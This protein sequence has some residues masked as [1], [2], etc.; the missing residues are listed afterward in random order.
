MIKIISIFIFLYIN[1]YSSVLN[2]TI[3][4]SYKDI[5]KHSHIK[6]LDSKELMIKDSKGNEITELSALAYD[7]NKLYALSDS[8]KLYHFNIDLSNDKIDKIELTKTFK[9]K[10][11]KGK[12]LKKIK[13]D[14][15]GLVFYDGKLLISFERKHRIAM[16]DLDGNYIKNKKLH[17]DLEN[18]ENFKSSNKG[19]ESV[20]YSKKYGVVTAPEA[21]LTTTDDK[22][23]TIYSKDK[24]WKFKRYSSITAL[25]FI[26]DDN[27]MILERKFSWITFHRV[28]TI[29]SIDLSS[30]ENSICKAKTL[31]VLDSYKN[32]KI[33][34]F[35]GLT[36]V[37]K[38]KFLMVSDDNG[39]FY[40]KTLLVLFEI[41]KPEF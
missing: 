21:P 27:L 22:Y 24:T 35:E 4:P 30:C 2:Y 28:T 15:E 12:R 36:K 23:H 9:L 25:E 8:G 38:D 40:Q 33:D 10:S 32:W 6:I 16:F 34:N 17:R 41:S 5:Q 31:A 13:R 19:L 11:K 37:G 29:S 3:E 7:S 14:S 20:A 18:L 39:M 1:L 26:D